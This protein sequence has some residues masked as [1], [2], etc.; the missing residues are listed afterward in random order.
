[1]GP[2][3]EAVRRWTPF[4][5]LPGNLGNGQGRILLHLEEMLQPVKQRENCPIL[6]K[7][8]EPTRPSHRIGAKSSI[9]DQN[10]PQKPSTL[11]I[12]WFHACGAG[13]IRGRIGGAPWRAVFG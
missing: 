11:S 8:L 12:S 5:L 3:G 10:F 13:E 7:N 6:L 4:A 9:Q 2:D 1:M